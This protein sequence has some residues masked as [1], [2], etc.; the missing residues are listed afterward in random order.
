MIVRSFVRSFVRLYD[1]SARSQGGVGRAFHVRLKWL[2][3]AVHSRV[4][5]EGARVGVA[6]AVE[7]AECLLVR[8]VGCLPVE[9]LPTVSS[10][11]FDNNV[12]LRLFKIN[13]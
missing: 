1:R 12:F 11:H 8:E 2:H 6:E 3:E 7:K 13:V 4:A 5:G 9:L 10:T